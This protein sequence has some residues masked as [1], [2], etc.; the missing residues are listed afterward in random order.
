ML[1]RKQLNNI[2][3]FLL[4][5]SLDQEHFCVSESYPIEYKGCDEGYNVC[6]QEMRRN[7]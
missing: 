2:S 1:P 5:F 3:I 4:Y 7:V 6:I